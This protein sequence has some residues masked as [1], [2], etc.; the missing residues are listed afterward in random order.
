MY[1]Y[2]SGC[3]LIDSGGTHYKKILLDG[4][5]E[6]NGK[7]VRT[8]DNKSDNFKYYYSYNYRGENSILKMEYCNL[9]ILFIPTIFWKTSKYEVFNEVMRDL[10]KDG[11]VQENTIGLVDSTIGYQLD[12]MFG[13]TSYCQYVTGIPVTKEQLEKLEKQEAIYNE[14]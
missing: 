13:I 14:I 10:K 9:G 5:M 7:G 8:R 1:L 6:L 3:Q 12:F 2:I 11:E 4:T